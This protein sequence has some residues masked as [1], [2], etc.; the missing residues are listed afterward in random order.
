MKQLSSIF[1]AMLLFCLMGI[2]VSVQ[3]DSSED[4]G[5]SVSEPS[6]TTV[7]QPESPSTEPAPENPADTPTSGTEE[8]TTQPTVPSTTE[9]IP[10]TPSETTT[11]ILNPDSCDHSWMYVEVDPT[12]TE[13]GGRGYVCIYCE[14]LSEL[15]AI[16]LLP[17]TYDNA[18][19]TQC[20]QC[21]FT[22]TVTHKYSAAWSRNSTQHW[23]ACSVCGA[24]SDSGSHYPGPAA[25]EE[26]AQYCLTCGLMM[27]PKKNH[28]HQYSGSYTADDAE[29]WYA[30]QGCEERKASEPHRYDNPCD[31]TCNVCGHTS[32]KE[33]AYGS[34]K[35][36]GNGH[37]KICSLCGQASAPE[38]HIPDKEQDNN[39]ICSICDFVLSD[40]TAHIHE[41]SEDWTW[42]ENNHWKQCGCGE[43]TEEALHLWDEGREIDDGV[44]HICTVCGA[45][46]LEPIAQEKTSVWVPVSIAVLL[47]AAIALV[48][49]VFVK[50]KYG[51]D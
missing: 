48:I 28:V 13:Y 26:K 46:K 49:F 51:K 43:V 35:S 27:T 30:C 19:D 31:G 36:D 3:A 37:W 34:W 32:N 22:R 11:P 23:H 29:H 12:C 47:G 42:D 41:A 44:W 50:V 33:H 45:E 18:C 9:P 24:K 38:Q 5:I 6:E 17:H 14:A 40:K 4:S 8:T 10:E 1:M 7:P 21:G 16:N 25:T 20:N 2:P 15:E 39:V